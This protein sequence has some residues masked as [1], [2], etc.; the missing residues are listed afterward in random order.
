MR[1]DIKRSEQRGLSLP[2]QNNRW[3]HLTG[4]SA[5]FRLL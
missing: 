4:I 1:T 3:L 5:A 2:Q